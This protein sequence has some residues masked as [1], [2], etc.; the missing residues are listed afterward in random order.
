MHGL[1]VER[2]KSSPLEKTNN[3]ESIM[4]GWLSYI[5]TALSIRNVSIIPHTK[6]AQHFAIEIQELAKGVFFLLGGDDVTVMSS[7]FFQRLPGEGLLISKG[8]P[9][10]H[11]VPL[12]SHVPNNHPICKHPRKATNAPIIIII[13][14]I[15]CTFTSSWK[16]CQKERFPKSGA[17][18]LISL[19]CSH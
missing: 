7:I 11:Q 2:R 17:I 15:I 5:R 18:F 9:S 14:I 1:E 8:Q 13:I 12:V 3:Q 4:W 16:S 10:L 19:I 6:E